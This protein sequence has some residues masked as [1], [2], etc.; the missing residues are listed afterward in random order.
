MKD[1]NFFSVYDEKSSNVKIVYL[2][3]AVVALVIVILPLGYR[4]MIKSDEAGLQSQIGEIN[5]WLGSAEVKTQL[6]QFDSR[7]LRIDNLRKYADALKK[8][9]DSIEKIGSLSTADFDSLAGVLPHPSRIDSFTYADR[10]V[11]MEIIIPDRA[12]AAEIISQLK[13][14]DSVEDVLFRSVTYDENADNYKL[15]VFCR[16]K[17]GVLK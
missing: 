16:M 8:S 15:S 3:A 14:A 13:Q 5:A 11:S 2:L 17:E 12:L 7:N 9:T 10:N 1:F 6:D 4:M